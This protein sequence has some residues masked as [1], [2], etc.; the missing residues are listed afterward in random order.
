MNFK[1]TEQ[2]YVGNWKSS[3]IPEAKKINQIMICN[4]KKFFWRVMFR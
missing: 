3:R 1:K 2:N 4:W